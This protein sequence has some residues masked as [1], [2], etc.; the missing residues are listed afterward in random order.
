MA[1]RFH[2]KTGVF[3][4][5]DDTFSYIFCILKNGQLGQLYYGKKLRDRE[6]FTHMFVAARR[7][8]APCVFEG[9]SDF[10]MEDIKQEYPVYGNGDMRSMACEIQSPDGSRS[11]DFKYVSHRIYDGK[12]KLSGLPCTYTESD[13]EAETLE[14]TL[15][16]ALLDTDLILSYSVFKG[17]PA[18][19]RNTKFVCRSEKHLK[20]VKAMSLS[21]DLPDADYEMTELAGAWGRERHVKTQPL[22]VG[23]QSIYSLRGHSSHMFNPFLMLKRPE[24]TENS[25]E[26]FGVSLIYSGNFLGQVEVDNYHVTR[27]M[28]GIHPEGFTWNLTAGVEF[29]TPEAVMVYSPNGMNAMSQAFHRLYRTR[30][31]RGYWRDRT[32]PVLINNWEATYMKFDEEKLV[33][34]AKKAKELGI[35]L[36][37]LDDGW[38]GHRDDDTTSL[39][40]W[41]ADKKKLQNGIEGVAEKIT[42]LGM[43]FGLWFEPEMISKDS[44]LYRAHPDYMLQTPGRVPCHGRNQ[45][46]LDFSREEVVNYV[47]ESMEK[48]LKSGKVSYVK[49]DMNRSITDGYSNAAN[50]E[51]QGE[52]LHR[53]ILGVYA[54]YERLTSEFPEVLF[55]SCASGGG[56]FDPGM[57]YYAPQGWTSD[58]TDAAERLKVQYGTSYCYPVSAM[59]SHVSAVPN[60]QVFRRTPMKTRADVAYFGTFGYELDVNKLPEE[61]QE[62]IKEQIA[63]RKQ[64]EKLIREGTFYRLVSPFDSEYG[65]T[66]WMVVSDDR[67]QALVGYYRMQQP[68]NEGYRWLKLSGLDPELEYDVKDTNYK[69]AADAYTYYGDELMEKGFDIS[70]SG[71]GPW[72]PWIYQGDY[73]SR[74]FI[75]EAV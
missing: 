6:D 72:T 18:L 45:Y 42:A 70:D 3:H 14:I 41:F 74:L 2:E 55:E 25:G 63:F 15:T 8:M 46:V 44:E 49:W 39:G 37:V 32:R 54:L 34:I 21:I 60:H 58:D 20:L 75:V 53:Q 27:I 11:S 10:S 23:I 16:D 4:I 1:I 35:E 33:G 26:V 30:L 31:A 52:V 47:A 13:D 64:Y 66:A 71:F 38:F 36:F 24:T 56:R 22:H 73:Q 61:E 68:V 40:D 62:Q 12:P 9:D 43:R 67:K 48:I 28:M 7:D 59:G 51:I 5:W 50:P 69:M 29:Q 57:L 65:E 19:V 17:C